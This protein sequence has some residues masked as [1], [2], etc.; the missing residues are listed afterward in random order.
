M[1]SSLEDVE[2]LL[3]RLDRS[4]QKVED[5]LVISLGVNQ[6]PVAIRI[7]DPVL[8]LQV[9]V[10]PTPSSDAAKLRLYQKLLEL[11]GSALLHSGYAL[12]SNTIVLV[13][14]LELSS[15]DQ[16]ELEAVLAD[17]DLALAEHVALLRQCIEGN[18]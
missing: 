17:F 12:M 7:S 10:G 9:E 6:T 4:F 2:A 14:A 13:S 8:V 16:N 1:V 5:T 11:N 15:L 3:M 18:E